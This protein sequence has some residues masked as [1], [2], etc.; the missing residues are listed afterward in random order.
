MTAVRYH[1]QLY[2]VGDQVMH[3]QATSSSSSSS[4]NASA[5]TGRIVMVYL[6]GGIEQ[7]EQRHV[8]ALVLDSGKTVPH[9]LSFTKLSAPVNVP[10][11]PEE[12][13]AV[14]AAGEKWHADHAHAAERNLPQ[15]S[16]GTACACKMRMP[17]TVLHAGPHACR[18]AQTQNRRGGETVVANAAQQAS[19]ARQADQAGER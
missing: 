17:D 3:S 18:K 8:Q 2:Q 15:Q 13:A 19:V 11:T 6:Q 7:G 9:A 12:A 1:H 5:R 16:R 4:T 14:K 10:M